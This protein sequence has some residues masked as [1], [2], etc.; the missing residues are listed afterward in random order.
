M[1]VEKLIK[2]LEKCDKTLEVYFEETQ[3]TK[4]NGV[5]IGKI[6]LVDEVYDVALCDENQISSPVRVVLTGNGGEE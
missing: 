3:T 5:E 6:T 1:T 2:A 4:E